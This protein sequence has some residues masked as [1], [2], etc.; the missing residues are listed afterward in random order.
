[1]ELTR[2]SRE[3]QVHDGCFSTLMDVPAHAL[4][5]TVPALLGAANIYCMVPGPTKAVAVRDTL[6]GPVT[7][8]CPATAMRDHSA[9]TLY[10]DRD[11]AAL[12]LSPGQDLREPGR[13]LGL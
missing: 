10:V 4:T 5:L 1:M 13:T 7:V 9:A 3:Q 2:E 12:C 8:D 11:S 6:R